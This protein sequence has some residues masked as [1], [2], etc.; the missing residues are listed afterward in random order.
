MAL[1]L[2][3]FNAL[4]DL[5]RPPNAPPAAADQT[6]KPCQLYLTS[7]NLLDIEPDEFTFWQ[8][9]VWL[10][11]P[12]GTDIRPHDIV[13]VEPGEGWFYEVRWTDRMHKNFPNEYFVAILCQTAIPSPPNPF[14][15]LM[16]SGDSLLLEDGSFILL[17]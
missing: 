10:R 15:L 14:H 2:P 5:W 12:K 6:N 3:N 7:R 17:E 4:Y 8:P 1:F 13:E 9:P 16:E 11:V